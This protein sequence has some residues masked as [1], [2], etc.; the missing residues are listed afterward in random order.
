[1][2]G[3]SSAGIGVLLSSLVAYVIVKSRFKARA[4]LDFLCWLPWAI[5]GICS[6]WRCCGRYC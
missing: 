1:V 5:P 6:A 2:L 3:F 4:L